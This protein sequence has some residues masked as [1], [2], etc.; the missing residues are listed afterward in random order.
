MTSAASSKASIDTG[1]LDAQSAAALDAE[2]MSTPGFSL[3]QLMEL[4][5][6]SVAE[7][8]YAV[9]ME[10]EGNQVKQRLPVVAPPS[11]STTT[12]TPTT[13]TGV[14]KILV[15]CGPGN[16]GGDGLVA[17]R[18]LVHFG[19]HCVVVYPTRISSSSKQPH[20][21][22]LVR[23][24]QDVGIEVRDD[25]PEDLLLYQPV[26]GEEGEE[27]RTMSCPYA[28][29]IDAIFGFSFH[30]EPREPFATMLQ[31][32]KQAQEEGGA[33]LV[34][35]DVPSGWEVDRGVAPESTVPS[36]NDTGGHGTDGARTRI[37][38]NVLVSL[39][40]PKLCAR[41]FPGRHFV[42]GRFLPPALAIQYGVRM[43]PYPGVSQVMQVFDGR[44]TADDA[45]Q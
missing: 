11:H 24:C 13:T 10:D 15:V 26:V 1:Y 39:T 33:L 17:A 20:Y 18:H 25:L 45:K 30:G 27:G 3:E 40:A 41:D 32:M 8:V 31:K 19:Y 34:A 42:G 44:D 16:N 14:R 2:L 6:L 36:D 43:P 21:A 37:M 4:A 7:A 23:Q 5:G 28:A 38:P 9:L 29:I 22:N 35:V 12:T